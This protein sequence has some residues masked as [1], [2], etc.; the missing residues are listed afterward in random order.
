[1]S[2]I[3]KVSTGRGVRMPDDTLDTAQRDVDWHALEIDDV[4]D[5]LGSHID[6][7]SS[8]EVNDRRAK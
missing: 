8:D 6:G 7:L 3:S 2:I 4:F 5:N 1:M